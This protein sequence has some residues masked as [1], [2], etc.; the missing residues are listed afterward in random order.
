MKR[1]VQCR[2]RSNRHLVD[3]LAAK[4][5]Q[6]PA[7]SVQLFTISHRSATIAYLPTPSQHHSI[8]PDSYTSY[9]TTLHAVA[10]SR[11]TTRLTP[12][13]AT[14]RHMI[15]PRT[16]QEIPTHPVQTTDHHALTSTI[17]RYSAPYAPP[18][19]NLQYHTT[20]GII[21]HHLA[22]TCVTTH[23]PA[24][25]DGADGFVSARYALIWATLYRMALQRR[26][27]IG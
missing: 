2:L 13:H 1:H 24:S 20:L 4:E 8:H 19:T 17:S 6:T 15:P 16:T 12:S 22:L 3:G 10:P 23:N 11:T 9:R 14:G 21:L 27:C 18:S 25:M 7:E 26:C 5:H